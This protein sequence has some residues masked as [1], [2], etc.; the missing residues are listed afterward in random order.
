MVIEGSSPPHPTDDELVA[1]LGHELEGEALRRVELHLARCATCRL[2]IIDAKEVLGTPRR[3]RWR[4]MAPVAA[5]AAAVLLFMAWPPDGPLPSERPIHRD[6]PVST[7][8]APVPVSPVGAT[9]EITDLVWTRAPGA[10]RYRLTLFDQEGSVLWRATTVDSLV[11]IPDSVVI[12][13]GEV[14]LWRVE[15]RVGWDVWEASELTRFQL[16]EVG[17]PITDSGGLR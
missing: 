14:Y 7:G 2:E 9:G 12:E 4:V 13:E 6:A 8:A 3:A 5:A 1:Y 16:E 10:D 15:G 11:S 17:A